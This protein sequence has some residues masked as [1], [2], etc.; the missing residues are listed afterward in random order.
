[1]DGAALTQAPLTAIAGGAAGGIPLLLQTCARETALY[2]LQDPG[3]A[4]QADRV[5]AGYFGPERAAAMLARYAAAYPDLDEAMLCGVTVM[6]DE[7]YVVRTER[8]ADAHAPHGPVW[9]S[10]YDGPYTGIEDDPDPDFAQ[11]APLLHGA[12]GGDGAGIWQGG[13]GVSAALHT[14]WGAFAANGDPGWAP[15]EPGERAAAIFA[16][17]GPCLEQDPFA[18]AR[19][20]WSG[21]HWQ[22]GPW[23][24]TEG[25]S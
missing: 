19:A 5:L 6:T 12:H 18:T 25:V 14:A 16:E 22:P 4:A 21:L 2:Q 1:V 20:I 15:Y 8:L 7:R 10:R 3:A 23:W 13:A 9:R 24:P 17:D 11:Y